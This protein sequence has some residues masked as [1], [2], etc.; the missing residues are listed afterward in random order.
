MELETRNHSPEKADISSR[1][2]IKLL[3]D[4]FYEKARKD[5][6][7]APLFE[8]N[9]RD[10]SSHLPIM[11]GFWEH[12]LFGTGNYE[13]NPLKKHFP[14]PLEKRH[15]D[16][17]VE[18]FTNNVDEHFSGPVSERSKQLAR[19]IAGT[20]QFRLGIEPEN[21]RHAIPNYVRH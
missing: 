15:F 3:V 10:W 5:R 21:A 6:D 14:L 17:W 20:F 1:D 13:G 2:Q 11:Y 9:I 7:L 18:L 12:L 8:N 4:S 16:V 19:N